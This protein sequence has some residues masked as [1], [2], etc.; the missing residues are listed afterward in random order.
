[1]K[2]ITFVL[3]FASLTAGPANAVDGGRKD[4]CNSIPPGCIVNGKLDRECVCKVWCNAACGGSACNCD[5]LPVAESGAVDGVVNE[6]ACQTR[7][8]KIL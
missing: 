8:D 7:I 5:I 3:L 4:V 1:M 2:L 6:D